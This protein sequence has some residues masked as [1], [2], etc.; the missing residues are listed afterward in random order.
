MTI[1]K[2]MWSFLLHHWIGSG[3]SLAVVVGIV[4]LLVLNPAAALKLASSLSGFVLD[5]VKALVEWARKPH[6]WWKIG[7]LTLSACFGLAS[8]TAYQQRQQVL[9][10][11]RT[12]AADADTCKR[13]IAEK[14]A[15]LK[16]Y[17]DQQAAFAKSA[18][19]E[20]AQLLVAQQQSA[21]ALALIQ[22][23]QEQAAKNN[24]AWWGQYAKRPDSCK[25]AQ[26]AMDVACKSV[27]EY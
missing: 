19:E 24:A 6:D 14:D 26:E 12:A 15:E 1:L 2:G 10:V 25:A 22:S 3:L 21:E 27:G 11:T 13:T 4:A 17:R 7:C 16:P 18:R 5:K 23:A 8:L 9:V 20:T